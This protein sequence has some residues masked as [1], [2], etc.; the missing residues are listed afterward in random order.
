MCETYL[1]PA[2]NVEIARLHP[3][4]ASSDAVRRDPVDRINPLI[5]AAGIGRVGAHVSHGVALVV[6]KDG[7]LGELVVAI[8]VARVVKGV[9]GVVVKVAQEEPIA[10][11]AVGVSLRGPREALAETGAGAARCNIAFGSVGDVGG[12]DFGPDRLAVGTD[13]DEVASIRK[14]LWERDAV[15]QRGAEDG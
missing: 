14:G 4:V 1:V 12:G 5:S 11:G 3:P 8:R 2:G 15:G 6:G 7:S 13:T 9:P 10:A